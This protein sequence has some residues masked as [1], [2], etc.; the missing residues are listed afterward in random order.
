MKIQVRSKIFETNSS[1]T[2]ALSVFKKD[3][4]YEIPTSMHLV[5]NDF[6]F[7]WEISSYNTPDDKL[8]YLWI[9]TDYFEDAERDEYRKKIISMLYAIGVT[10]F[11]W[12]EGNGWGGYVD[13][14]SEALEFLTHILSD[15]D[16]FEGFIF[17]PLSMINT[18]NDNDDYDVSFETG[19][20]YTYY[21]GN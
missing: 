12:E 5:I 6:S 10:D 15:M 16:L 21:K 20:D 11:T 2:H 3:G 19:A 8:A 14:G 17:N 18:G 7:G 9:L 1:S 13:H 4:D